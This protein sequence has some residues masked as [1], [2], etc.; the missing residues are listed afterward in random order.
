MNGQ[1]ARRRRDRRRA[2]P[3]ISRINS[4][5][6]SYI[7]PTCKLSSAKPG[8]GNLSIELADEQVGRQAEINF[9]PAQIPAAESGSSQQLTWRRSA[10]SRARQNN[11]HGTRMKPVRP[12]VLISLAARAS[13]S[14]DLQSQRSSCVKVGQARLETLSACGLKAQLRP[15]AGPTK[16]GVW[17]RAG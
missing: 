13:K 7:R 17:A 10:S 14:I 2:R 3:G 1:A 9:W 15:P 8:R 11:N 5:I 6:T 16:L 4:A 12:R